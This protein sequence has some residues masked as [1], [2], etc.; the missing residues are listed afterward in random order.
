LVV[1]QVALSLVLLVGAGLLMRSFLRLQA[2]DPGFNASSLLTAEVTLPRGEYSSAEEVNQFFS[3]LVANLEAR[4]A[5]ASVAGI[6]RL[7]IATAGGDYPVY[8]EERPPADPSERRSAIVRTV[9]SGYFETM[10]IP[11]LVG[12]ALSEMDARDV[13]PVTVVDESLVE[14]YFP[15]E[16][17]L[18][19]NL[20]LGFNEPLPVR[21]VGVVR[22]VHASGLAGDPYPH[23]YFSVDQ[24]PRLE[25]SVVVRTTGD[26]LSVAGALREVVK[27]LD[28]RVPVSKVAAMRQVI[29]D[30]I[31]QPRATMMFLGA[32]ASVALSLAM[33]GL[34]GVLAYF[35]NQRTH[36]IGVRIA[37]GAAR[38][39][40]LRLVLHRGITLVGLG[41]VLGIGGAIGTTRF[42]RSLLFGVS[43]T[44]VVTYLVVSVVL[45]VVAVA[46]CAVPTWR[47]T[48]VD[49]LTALRVE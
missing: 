44:D 18:G 5:V 48:R 1:G 22:A 33:L 14:R 38:A 25:M 19:K 27:E 31:A 37:L 47:A 29:S 40:L 26:P 15:G 3:G 17:P 24:W 30:S 23:M 43:A 36:E 32:Y 21:I 2:V 34:Y 6:S 8:P 20:M 39:S 41:I 35:V 49:A 16:N 4:P 9:T 12:R 42:A 11:V 10:Q 28:S 13:S 45:L 46:A 7:P